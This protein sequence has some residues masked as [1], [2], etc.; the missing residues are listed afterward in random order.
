MPTKG[1]K[2]TL[3]IL[4]VC[5]LNVFNLDCGNFKIDYFKHEMK[6]LTRNG[7]LIASLKFCETTES[8][9][10]GLKQF[11]GNFFVLKS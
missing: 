10:T 4:I 2:E 11:L 8:F 1:E 5:G 3:N 7:L 9:R 6:L